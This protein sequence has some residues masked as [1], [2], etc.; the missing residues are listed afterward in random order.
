MSNPHLQKYQTPLQDQQIKYLQEK[1]NFTLDFLDD[2]LQRRS[3]E[4]KVLEREIRDAAC[5]AADIFE[6]YISKNFRQEGLQERQIRDRTFCEKFE[7]VADEIDSIK[8]KAAEQPELK[9]LWGA[10]DLHQSQRTSLPTGP[11]RLASS[12]RNDK[13]GFR[14]DV[15]QII[16][17]LT[18]YPPSLKVIPIIGMGGI[19]K[20]TLAKN[21]YNDPHIEEHF[22]IRAWAARI[23]IKDFITSAVSHLLLYISDT[24]S[25]IQSMQKEETEEVYPLKEPL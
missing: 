21:V 2:S 9:V 16:D 5:E 7:I 11:S 13:V 14:E 25:K 1:L 17:R 24:F 6:S 20:T 22:Y 12:G 3:E 19:G 8:G 23:A 10:T 18:G 4:I 15:N